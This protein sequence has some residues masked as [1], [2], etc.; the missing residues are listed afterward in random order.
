LTPRAITRLARHVAGPVCRNVISTTAASL[1]KR[2]TRYYPSYAQL[3]HWI[4]LALRHT[5]A[6]ACGAREECRDC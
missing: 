6:E 5:V 2:S 3:L 4:F 1:N